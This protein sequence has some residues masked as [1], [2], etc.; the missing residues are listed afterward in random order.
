MTERE[1]EEIKT[2]IKNKE[3]ENAQAKGKMESIEE[4]WRTK[5]GCS[6]LEEAENKLRELEA[7]NEKVS[8]KRDEYFEKLKNLVD[9]ESV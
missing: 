4:M 3:I 1:F 6:S 7:E 9:W 2:K 5:Y 8:A